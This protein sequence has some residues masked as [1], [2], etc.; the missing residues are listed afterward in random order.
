MSCGRSWWGL[1]PSGFIKSESGY[2]KIKVLKELQSFAYM[3]EQKNFLVSILVSENMFEKKNCESF[4][5]VKGTRVQYLSLTEEADDL[6]DCC[7]RDPESSRG[8]QRPAHSHRPWRVLVRHPG[9]GV[10]QLRVTD[11]THHKYTLVNQNQN[12]Y[13]S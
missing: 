10:C 11:D 8:S 6:I 7:D 12:K 1:R 2:N 5:I 4:W 13:I 9:A 3:R